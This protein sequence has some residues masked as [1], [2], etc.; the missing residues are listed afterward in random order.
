MIDHAINLVESLYDNGDLSIDQ[1]DG[2]L[3]GLKARES[4][5]AAIKHA[6][7]IAAERRCTAHSKMGRMDIVLRDA[8]PDIQ[9]ALEKAYEALTLTTQHLTGYDWNADPLRITLKQG[10]AFEAIAGVLGK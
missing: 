2:I 6:R 3:K 9:E 5:I 10:E 1:A 4:T 8:L 7:A